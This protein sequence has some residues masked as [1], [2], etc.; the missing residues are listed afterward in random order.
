[1]RRR[2]V[3]DAPVSYGEINAKRDKCWIEFDPIYR[4][5]RSETRALRLTDFDVRSFR[6]RWKTKN[7]NRQDRETITRKINVKN[8]RIEEKILRNIFPSNQDLI[9]IITLVR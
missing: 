1:M 8:G 2:C 4:G 9:V 3:W 7:E 5:R 6:S